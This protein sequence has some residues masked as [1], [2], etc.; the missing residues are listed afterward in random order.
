MDAASHRAITLVA[1]LLCLS[2]IPEAFAQSCRPV[3]LATFGPVGMGGD[4]TAVFRRALDSMASQRQVLYVPVSRKP[5]TV[6]PLA[7]PSHTKLCLSAGVVIQAAP[8]YGEYDCLLNIKDVTDVTISGYSAT[9]Q[10]PKQEYTEGQWRHCLSIRGATS[11]LVKGLSCNNSGGD[12]VYISGS[13]VKPYSEG[14]VIEDVTCDDNR[15]QGMSIISAQ[16]LLVSQSRFTNTKGTNPQDGIDLEPNQPIDRLVN[17]RI[18]D[19]VTAGNAGDGVC[20]SLAR[21]NGASL[22]VSITFDHHL[23]K[24]PGRSG[25]FMLGSG[26]A[27]PVTGT[28]SF[29]SFASQSAQREGVRVQRWGGTSLRF[30]DLSI[31]NPDQSGLPAYT[32]GIFIDSSSKDQA[33]GGNISIPSSTIRDSTGRMHYYFNVLDQSGLGWRHLQIAHGTWSGALYNS[34]GL[35]QRAPVTSVDVP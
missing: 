14:I 21:L 2:L 8:G 7:V 24:G 3:S 6:R 34:Y 30:S 20:V 18:E 12:G 19:C 9:L 27:N 33:P 15:R 31:I 10:M 22:P 1:A 13:A 4:D 16:N 23:D 5:Y 26:G 11:V 32:V 29:T 35:Y 25:C 17:V 28:V